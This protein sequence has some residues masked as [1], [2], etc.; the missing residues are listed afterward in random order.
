[1]HDIFTIQNNGIYY[2][3]VGNYAGSC[4]IKDIYIYSGHP[5]I[6]IGSSF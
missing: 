2:L 5:A 1:M 3:S 4:W 6:I